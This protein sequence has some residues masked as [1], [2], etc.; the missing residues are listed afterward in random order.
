MLYRCLATGE[1]TIMHGRWSYYPFYLPVMGLAR[2][3]VSVIWL[4]WI[5][6][7]SF[8]LL[9][10]GALAGAV[11]FA[12]RS[13]P[14]LAAVVAG[15]LVGC[16][17]GQILSANEAAHVSQ[18]GGLLLLV[19]SCADRRTIA[20]AGIPM[21][22]FLY[23]CHPGAALAFGA[24]AFVLV[25][26]YWQCRSQWLL[27]YAAAALALALARAWTPLAPYERDELTWAV[28]RNH[29]F[30]S[31]YGLPLVFVAAAL[32]AVVLAIVADARA[33]RHTAPTIAAAIL[34]AGYTV[35]CIVWASDPVRWHEAL[36]YRRF[37][38]PVSLGILLPA[39]TFDLLFRRRAG[40]LLLRPGTV[41]RVC[42]GGIVAV[43]CAALLIQGFAFHR[44]VLRLRDDLA[45]RHA[46]LA[47]SDLSWTRQTPLEGWHLPFNVLLAQ[48]R[49]PESL[50]MADPD[51]LLYLPLEDVELAPDK[52]L[53]PAAPAGYLDY[54]SVRAL[55]GALRNG[56]EWTAVPKVTAGGYGVELDASGWWVWTPDR[57]GVVFH[58]RGRFPAVARLRFQYLGL[59]LPRTL[60]LAF[61][62]GSARLERS[63]SLEPGWHDWTSEPLAIT[64]PAV[65]VDF[66]SPK[67]P[68]AIGPRDQRMAAFLIK[69]ARL[70]EEPN[71]QSR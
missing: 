63:L 13:T 34:L 18:I 46:I 30:A 52:P 70:I 50:L 22:I 41:L 8:D 53:L 1:P 61:R 32:G 33:E 21:G 17:P 42:T 54:T 57:L 59:N 19:G 49:R 27:A 51:Q 6:G 25:L 64:A 43:S 65:S 36:D 62:Q 15:L 10:A 14:L 5:F 26:R 58:V 31:F 24:L 23:G 37:A 4:E 28:T 12:W 44:L 55:A 48:G 35:A 69:N 39:V 47:L 56:T 38:L 60:V 3:G 71:T 29:F 16:L 7:L 9:T 40:G 2:L 67:P 66:A 20:V 45:R 68:V 11:Y